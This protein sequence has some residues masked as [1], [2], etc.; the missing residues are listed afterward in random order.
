MAE[1]YAERRAA[2]VIPAEKEKPPEL[3]S[4]VIRRGPAE[5][6]SPIDTLSSAKANRELGR[7]SEGTHHSVQKAAQATVLASNVQMHLNEGS[8]P[9]H[10]RFIR[11]LQSI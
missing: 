11:M 1:T 5:L 8:A 9:L 4:R 6:H 7:H 3:S 2:P 10:E